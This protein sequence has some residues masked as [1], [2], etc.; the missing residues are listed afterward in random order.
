VNDD[1][2]DRTPFAGAYAGLRVLVT[3]HT[4]F[5]GAWAVRW[6]S[7]LGAEVV[8]FS[9]GRAAAPVAPPTDLDHAAGDIEDPERVQAVIHTRAPHLVLHLAGQTLVSR[10]FAAPAQTFRANLLGSVNVLDAALSCPDVEGVLLLGTPAGGGAVTGPLGP[11]AASK[12]VVQAVAAGYAHPATQR[13]FRERP[14][15]VSVV[16]PGVMIGGDWAA[17]RLVPEVVRAVAAGRPVSLNSP[18]AARPWQH[19]LDGL[20]GILALGRH[21]LSGGRPRLSYDFGR[22]GSGPAETTRELVTALLA[23]L[24]VPDWPV[25]CATGQ[26]GDRLWLGCAGATE[27]LGWVPVWPLAETAAATATWYRHALDDPG[28][29]GVRCDAQIR[30]Y[31]SD[32]RAGRVRWAVGG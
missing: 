4:G 23:G 29:T 21:I 11:Y 24:G 9:R 22:P 10:G 6:L 8:G 12:Q 31:V 1:S 15:R 7:L 2:T 20:S 14:L 18:G 32:A 17:D 13:G 19:V 26:E 16:R 27:D 28:S 5:V 3:G 30:S 25:E